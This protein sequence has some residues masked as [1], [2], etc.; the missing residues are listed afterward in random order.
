MTETSD[1]VQLIIELNDKS[2]R[3]ITISSQKLEAMGS[4]LAGRL[5]ELKLKDIVLIVKPYYRRRVNNFLNIF[6]VEV[7]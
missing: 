7:R 5:F 1:D 4:L 6:M 2:V 3:K